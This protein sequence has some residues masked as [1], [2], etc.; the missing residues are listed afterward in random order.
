MHKR[1][2]FQLGAP[3]ISGKNNLPNLSFKGMGGGVNEKKGMKSI[4]KGKFY[5]AI[6]N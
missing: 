4:G 3:S 2:P 5:L 6:R 1:S